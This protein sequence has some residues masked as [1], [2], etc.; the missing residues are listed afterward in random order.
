M[1]IIDIGT[2]AHENKAD[3]RAGGE[4]SQ[5]G[6]GSNESAG[7]DNARG[8]PRG[9]SPHLP[10]YTGNG[11]SVSTPTG[12]PWQTDS[13]A[14]LSEAKVGGC[15][16]GSP[17][18]AMFAIDQGERRVDSEMGRAET[19]VGQADVCFVGQRGRRLVGGHGATNMRKGCVAPCEGG[20]A[21]K[22]F[23]R[24][25]LKRAGW[26]A[27]AKKTR[28]NRKAGVFSYRTPTLKDGGLSQAGGPPCRVLGSEAPVD[29]LSLE[30][31]RGRDHSVV[32]GTD[33]SG[34]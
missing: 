32:G 14:A 2:T 28:V 27:S 20:G 4:D 1:V 29:H 9:E 15:W 17:R 10:T 25:L 5:Q 11:Y 30:G 12:M 16:P 3:V 19:E 18:S 24:T 34:W 13:V 21:V 7:G 6:K 31:C 33:L 26:E 8:R 23:V 22:V